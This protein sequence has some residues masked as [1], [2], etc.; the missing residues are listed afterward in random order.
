MA[1]RECYQSF[2]RVIHSN[3]LADSVY[4]SGQDVAKL[5]HILRRDEKNSINVMIAR[6]YPGRN[7]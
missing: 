7:N 2:N 4:F 5:G 1:Q 3:P 6:R